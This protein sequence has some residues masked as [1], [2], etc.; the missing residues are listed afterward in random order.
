MRVGLVVFAAL[1]IACGPK[2]KSYAYMEIP[3]LPSDQEV[4]VFA[5]TLPECEYEQVGLIAADD[6]K[7]TK[8]RA[9][10]MGADGIIGTVEA[11][12]SGNNPKAAVCG[13]PK[14]VTFNTVAIRFSDPA[15]R[16]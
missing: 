2:V 9:R 1:F 4:V 5:E 13:T 10:K 6:L 12:S 16:Y 3:A 8:D 14:C 15:C 11:D 7:R